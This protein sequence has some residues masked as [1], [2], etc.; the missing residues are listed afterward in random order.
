MKIIY[1]VES[2]NEGQAGSRKTNFANNLKS[3]VNIADGSER[4]TNNIYQM[5]FPTGIRQRGSIFLV[6]TITNEV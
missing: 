3:A 1:L 2:K 6:D 5:I 4:V